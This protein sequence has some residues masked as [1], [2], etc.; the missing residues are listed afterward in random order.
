MRVRGG[1]RRERLVI[2]IRA[3][4]PAVHR[5]MMQVLGRRAHGLVPSA[6]A[7]RYVELQPDVYRAFMKLAWL[8]EYCRHARIGRLVVEDFHRLYPDTTFLLE[9]FIYHPKDCCR[10]PRVCSRIGVISCSKCL[11][12]TWCSEDCLSSS[13]AAHQ[14]YCNF[15]FKMREELEL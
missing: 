7:S 6:L 9:R 13:Y 8:L 1:D 14:E 4:S 11:V 10:Q 3:P 2:A 15:A 12:A 5:D